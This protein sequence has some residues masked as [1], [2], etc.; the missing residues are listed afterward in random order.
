[1]PFSVE[2]TP[3]PGLLVATPDVYR[4][5]RGFFVEAYHRERYAAYRLP[6][7]F[8][9]DNHSRS[10][11]GVIRGIHY[12]DERAPMGKLV[13]CVRG[14]IFDVAVDLRAGSPTFGHWHG[15]TLDDEALRQLWVPP[16][17][18]HAFAALSETADVEY[19]CTGLYAPEAEHTIHWADAD[20][21]ITWP[22]ADPVVSAR[23]REGGSFASYRANP[24]FRW[25][26]DES[27]GA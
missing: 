9:Q 10:R 14:S 17:F 20:L 12:Q 15:L 6:F 4:D 13:R 3:I 24:H 16:G 19:K 22:F 7:E 2:E 11:R 25:R 5:D 1:M 23:D 26:A 21:A 8:V 18:G 27:A